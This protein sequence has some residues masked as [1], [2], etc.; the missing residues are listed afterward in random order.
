MNGDPVT[1]K[2][3]GVARRFFQ[4]NGGDQQKLLVPQLYFPRSGVTKYS[5]D[6]SFKIS[7]GRTTAFFID[8]H[9]NGLFLEYRLIHT[10]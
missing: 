7:I 5:T 10:L 8:K 2:K 6:G 1:D 9:S 3:I 4:I